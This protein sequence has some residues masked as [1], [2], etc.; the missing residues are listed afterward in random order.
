M[1]PQEL[2]VALGFN[3]EPP[4]LCVTYISLFFINDQQIEA[5]WLD[6]NTFPS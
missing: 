4:Q 1:A 6:D 5:S 2:A 3:F